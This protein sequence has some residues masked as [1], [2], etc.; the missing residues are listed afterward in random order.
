[1]NAATVVELRFPGLAAML[2][3][4]RGCIRLQALDF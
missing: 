2:R 3:A 1:M 4:S